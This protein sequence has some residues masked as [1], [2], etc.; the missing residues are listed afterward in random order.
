MKCGLMRKLVSWEGIHAK[1]L[2]SQ[3]VSNDVCKKKLHLLT[4]ERRSSYQMRR[5]WKKLFS[6]VHKYETLS[7]TNTSKWCLK[8]TKRR[9]GTD[10]NLFVKGFL[11]KSR[12]QNY[13]E[14]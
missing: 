13:E 7:R 6:V 2:R 8:A 14:L 10:L 3:T 5:N 4:C 1:A 11:G 9:L 12:A